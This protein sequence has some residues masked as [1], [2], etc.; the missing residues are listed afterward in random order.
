M[1]CCGGCVHVFFSFIPV[2]VFWNNVVILYHV[3]DIP[4]HIFSYAALVYCSD[5]ENG[6]IAIWLL[7]LL[8]EKFVFISLQFICECSS[9][10]SSLITAAIDCI[11]LRAATSVQ[12]DLLY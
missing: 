7:L 5:D 1:V 10:I 6:R 2:T 9:T 4:F 8:L 3:C 11:I 12:S